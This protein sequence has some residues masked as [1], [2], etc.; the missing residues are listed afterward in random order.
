MLGRCSMA[1]LNLYTS[2]V[3]TGIESKNLLLCDQGGKSCYLSEYQ[4]PKETDYSYFVDQRRQAVCVRSHSF[5]VPE[6]ELMTTYPR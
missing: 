1:E 5:S 2:V 3:I 6:A 4:F